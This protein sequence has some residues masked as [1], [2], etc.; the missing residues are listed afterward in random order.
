[1][2]DLLFL[3]FIKK[4]ISNCDWWYILT[5]LPYLDF[6]LNRTNMQ[7]ENKLRKNT[8]FGSQKAFFQKVNLKK[9]GC[10]K[11]RVVLYSGE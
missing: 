6:F 8:R 1:M 10:L 5:I 9:G 4:Y 2:S 11:I 7:Y 3:R